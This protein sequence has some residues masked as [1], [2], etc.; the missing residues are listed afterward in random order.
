MKIVQPKWAF[1]QVAFTPRRGWLAG[2][3]PPQPLHFYDPGSGREVA[4]PTSH[5]GPYSGEPWLHFSPDERV[6]SDGYTLIDLGA[7]WDWVDAPEGDPPLLRPCSALESAPDWQSIRLCRT[8][9][10]RAILRRM[11]GLQTWNMVDGLQTWNMAEGRLEHERTISFPRDAALAVSPDGEWLAWTKGP[12]RVVV[13]SPR[14]SDW[15][16]L[17]PHDNR[18]LQSVFSPDGR[19][20]ATM[21]IRPSKVSLW[22]VPGG[23][24]L[25]CFKAFNSG[26]RS[27]AF[28]PSGRLL[29][30][31]RAGEVRFYDTIA[32]RERPGLKMAGT[33][34]SIAFSP[35]GSLMAT[36]GLGK[37]MALVDLED[38][39]P[40]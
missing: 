23:R 3:R 37:G 12:E 6:A 34:E 36:C 31:G 1:S 4:T 8:S 15:L 17:L 40:V 30:A 11:V 10:L 14:Q 24:L 21:T 33:V 39:M 25:A 19:I 7:W 18:P 9:P 26:A 29:A 16:A 27:L 38:L 22:E 28:H 2:W 13:L 32:L 5:L 20:L 35:D